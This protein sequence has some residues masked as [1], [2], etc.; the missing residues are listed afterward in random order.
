MIQIFSSFIVKKKWTNRTRNSGQNTSGVDRVNCYFPASSLVWVGCLPVNEL[1]PL[2]MTI[3]IYDISPNVQFI[4]EKLYI[5]YSILN[6]KKKPPPTWPLTQV[7]LILAW[8]FSNKTAVRLVFY[9]KTMY[10]LLQL[11]AKMT[12]SLLNP[13]HWLTFKK[14]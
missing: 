13:L 1:Y 3:Y 14:A 11:N 5:I 2:T 9:T 4:M 8:Y 6:T 7:R 10:S 12:H